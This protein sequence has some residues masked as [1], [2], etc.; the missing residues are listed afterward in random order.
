MQ[1]KN[2]F[3]VITGLAVV[4]SLF[5]GRTASASEADQETMISFN[6]PVEMPGQVLLPGT[7]VF[8]LADD[9][10]DLHTVEVFNSDETKLYGTFETIPT[11]RS[12]S[13]NATAF[14][15]AESSSGTPDAVVK[16]FY[17]GSRTGNEF[18]YPANQE[19][20]LAHDPQQTILAGSLPTNW[21][22]EAGE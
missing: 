7:Y 6:A 2:K 22:P 9:G 14:T 5:F 16:W 15:L 20:E 17:P 4:S 12:R 13:T 10:A 3:Y 21:E 18:L 11:D 1:R 8:K 19:K